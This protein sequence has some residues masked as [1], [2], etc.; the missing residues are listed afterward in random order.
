MIWLIG[1]GDELYIWLWKGWDVVWFW[2]VVMSGLGEL[3]VM[4]G[5]VV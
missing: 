4:G 5:L 1:V 2:V 3:L